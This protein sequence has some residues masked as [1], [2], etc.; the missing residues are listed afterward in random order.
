MLS[1]TIKKTRM[2]SGI[3][4]AQ[5]AKAL[6]MSEAQYSRKE[7]GQTKL[8]L[9]EAK[10]IANL[11]DLNERVTEKFWMAD[12]IYY[13]MKIDKDLVY[14]ALKIVEMYYDNYETC[15]EIPNKNNSYSSLAERMKHRRKK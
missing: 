14:E 6:F 10:Q 8:S 7:N 9:K 3:T 2:Y 12:T 13:L 5:M 15:V 1:E 4:Q 11:L